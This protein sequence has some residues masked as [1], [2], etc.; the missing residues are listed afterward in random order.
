VPVFGL[1]IV[2]V[3]FLESGAMSIFWQGK[4]ATAL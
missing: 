2:V 4:N 3:F 1:K